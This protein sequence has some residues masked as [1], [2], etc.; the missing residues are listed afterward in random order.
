MEQK[1]EWSRSSSASQHS[2]GPDESAILNQWGDDSSPR[3]RR[4]S[5]FSVRTISTARSSAEF[6]VD[7]REMPPPPSNTRSARRSLIVA[8]IP[9]PF[10]REAEKRTRT[11]SM[12]TFRRRNSGH[13]VAP[14]T[15]NPPKRSFSPLSNEWTNGLAEGERDK[16]R[17][18]TLSMPSQWLYVASR[19][20]SVRSVQTVESGGSTRRRVDCRAN[21]SVGS[22]LFRSGTYYSARSSFSTFG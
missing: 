2:E 20:G 17:D 3:E 12:G 22:D 15:V 4:L 21:G 11:V 16:K 8:K 9:L 7:P 18:S 19:E 6:V 10:G 5:A 13:D 1:A 14:D